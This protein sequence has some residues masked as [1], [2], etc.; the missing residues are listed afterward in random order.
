MIKTASGHY[1]VKLETK[2]KDN[3]IIYLDDKEDDLTEFKAI[4][5]LHEVNNHKSDHQL[6]NAYSK[7]G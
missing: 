1:G 3:E 5:K 2:E 4:R 7:A 6:I